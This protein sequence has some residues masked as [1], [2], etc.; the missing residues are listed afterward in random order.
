MLEEER[1]L[2]EEVKL[3]CLIQ[4]S[5]TSEWNNTLQHMR[6]RMMLILTETEEKAKAEEVE[7]VSRNGWD[8]VVEAKCYTDAKDDVAEVSETGNGEYSNA[9]AGSDDDSVKYRGEI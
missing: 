3:L 1:L 2:M 4:Y 6:Q 8:E 9:R 7:S 5:A